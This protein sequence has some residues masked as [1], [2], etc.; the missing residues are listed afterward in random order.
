MVNTRKKDGVFYTPKFITEYIINNTVAKLC[1]EKKEELSLNVEIKDTKKANAGLFD[2]HGIDKQIIEK[3]LFGVDINGASVG[4]AKLSLWLQTAKRDRPL[5]NLMGNI[6]SANSL[7][8][9][10][11]KLF[12]EI[13]ANGGFDCVVWNPPYV[14]QESIKELK[15][16]LKEIYSVFTGTAD[17]FVYFYELAQNILKTNGMNGFICS[18]KFFRAKYGQN[19]REMILSKTTI[20]SIVD[21]KAVVSSSSLFSIDNQK[22]YLLDTSWFIDKGDKFLLACLNSKVVWYYLKFIT[23][24]LGNASLRLKKIFMEKLPIPNIP[25][26]EQKPFITLVDTIIESKEK[27]VKFNK[28]FD[29]LNAVDKIEIKE[30]IEKLE[31]LVLNSVNEIDSLVYELYGLNGD[32]IKIVDDAR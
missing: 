25:K 30:E 27:I 28:H 21:F 9:D 24:T 17:L 4:I 2:Y 11:A 20:K 31:T 13:M 32:E 8:A 15:P 23:S 5:S 16:A 14:R 1:E 6:K 26:E 18:N 29:N 19:L 7:T 3:N 12:P 22:S 10:W